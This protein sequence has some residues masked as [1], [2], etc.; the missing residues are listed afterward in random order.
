MN[1]FID[2]ALVIITNCEEKSTFDFYM[3]LLGTRKITANDFEKYEEWSD[4]AMIGDKLNELELALIEM[5]AW[6]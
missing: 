1:D 3:S 5:E 2:V 6:E 4:D